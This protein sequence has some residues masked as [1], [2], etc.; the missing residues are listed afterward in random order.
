MTRVQLAALAFVVTLVGCGNS[1]VAAGFVI[2]VKS[3]SITQVDSFV[4]R[5]PDGAEL[6]FR[7]GP[8]EL[9][10]GAF[11][12]GHLREHMALNQPVAVAYREENGERIAYRLKDAEWLQP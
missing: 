6:H 8:T 11:P 10:N 3:T 4:L 9:D 2:Q 12:A 1:N 5:T 7:V